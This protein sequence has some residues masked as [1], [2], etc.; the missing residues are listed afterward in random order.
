MVKYNENCDGNNH[1]G[2]GTNHHG[3]ENIVFLDKN[4][5]NE[6]NFPKIIENAFQNPSQNAYPFSPQR[7]SRRISKNLFNKFNK[8]NTLK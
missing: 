5:Q 8:F 1:H 3:Y 7:Q 4:L 6:R 2:Y